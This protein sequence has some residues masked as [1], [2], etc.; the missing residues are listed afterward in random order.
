VLLA[1]RNPFEQLSSVYH[2]MVKRHRYTKSYNHFIAEN[3][4]RCNALLRASA[5]VQALE[6]IG[7]PY[8]LRNYSVLRDQ[9]INAFASAIGISSMMTKPPPATRVNRSLS[10]TELQLLLLVNAICGTS[11][12][13]KL[14]DQ[15]VNQL[16]NVKPVT[17]CMHDISRQ[18]VEAINRPAMDTL[19]TR[20]PEEIPLTMA[21]PGGISGDFHCGLSDAQ[22]EI[23]RHALSAHSRTARSSTDNPG[24]QTLATRHAHNTQRLITL[25]SRLLA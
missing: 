16:P 12:G 13:Q 2:Q 1:V 14:A 20:L 7:V 17:L 15:L 22:L 3:H 9:L 5:V 25:I 23:C 11:V 18:Q 6:R 19:N 10:A 8:T 24:L 21:C 4:Y